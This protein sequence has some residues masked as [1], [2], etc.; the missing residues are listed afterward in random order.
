MQNERLKSS[1]R[2][3]NGFLFKRNE[4]LYRQ[5]NKKYQENY[6]LLISSG[7][8]EKLTKKNLLIDHK[9]VEIAPYFAEI[10][11][12]VIQPELV[13]FIS[14]P[15]E[16][17]FSQLKNAAL[18]TLRIQ[19]EALNHGMT[20][21]DASAYNIQFANGKAI[22]IDSLSFEK[23]QKGQPWVAYRQF[24]Q[25]FLAPLALMALRD[26]RL[27]QLLRVYIDGVPL[28]LASKLLPWSSHLNFGLLTHIHTH[29]RIQKQF[30]DSEGEVKKQTGEI[31]LNSLL[32]LIDSL[33]SVI[34]N[35]K[36]KPAGT[37]WGEYYSATNYSNE[38]FEEK[39]KMVK[40]YLEVAGPGIV[41]DLGANTG[42]FS[43]IACEAG[44]QTVSFD[45][46]PAA[47]EKNYLISKKEKNEL[48]LPLVMDLTNPSAGIGWQ[49][50]ERFSLIERGPANTVMALAL[51]HHLAISNNVPL[52]GIAEYF[53]QLGKWLIIEFVPKLDSQVKRLLSS[54]EDIF[55]HYTKEDFEENFKS[56][57][58]IVKSEP[59]LGTERVLYL[60]KSKE[61]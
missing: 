6:D 20:L 60:F 44:M 2:D 13:S 27:N 50:S 36:W 52:L 59:I 8:F 10:A 25:H 61:Y 38:A 31:S 15:Y 17:S 21:K 53:S 43:K 11:Y 12:L 54:R 40:E 16:W 56:F 58:E 22:L 28:D 18:T 32:G 39:A 51:I 26:I 1:F 24:C 41:W 34:R 57:F 33:E 9:Q 37:E 47:V 4:I 46:D 23:Y 29:A 35:L 45:I 14:Y 49:N 7:L 5:V 19:K 48:I 55:D 30:A 3:P 42:A